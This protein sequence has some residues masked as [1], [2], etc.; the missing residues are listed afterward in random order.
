MLWASLSA[1]A[2]R[3]S[4]FVSVTARPS[5][6]ARLHAVFSRME[7]SHAPIAR[8]RDVGLALDHLPITA[9]DPAE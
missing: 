7:P 3:D 2:L 8:I 6:L 9:T 1:R 4:Y 5:S